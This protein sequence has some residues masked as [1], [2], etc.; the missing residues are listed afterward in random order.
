MGTDH[1]PLVLLTGPRV[2][3]EV[4]SLGRLKRQAG[5]SAVLPGILSF[6]AHGFP[7]LRR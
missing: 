1:R 6:F 5:P 3:S 4:A 2:I 7:T